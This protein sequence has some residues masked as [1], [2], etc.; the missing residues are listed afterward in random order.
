MPTEIRGSSNFDSDSAGKV[1][2]QY[3]ERDYTSISSA[4]GDHLLKTLTINKLSTTSTIQIVANVSTLAEHAGSKQWYFYK[5]G[6]NIGETRYKTTG[7][8]S[9]RMNTPPVVGTFTGTAGSHTVSFKCLHTV[10][11][12][13]NYLT[14]YG[15]GVTSYVITEVEA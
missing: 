13:Y 3:V 4:A 5:G 8:G 14:A 2:Q 1:L 7:N 9:W 6:V 12:Y 15:N 10:H 11:L